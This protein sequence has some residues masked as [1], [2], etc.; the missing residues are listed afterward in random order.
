VHTCAGEGLC[1]VLNSD[2]AAM[3]L[4]DADGE[5]RST[6]VSQLAHRN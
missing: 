6:L 3:N 2:G 1:N 5:C 4:S